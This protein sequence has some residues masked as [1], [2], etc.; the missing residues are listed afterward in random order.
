MEP[1]PVVAVRPKETSLPQVPAPPAQ[2]PQLT[3]EQRQQAYVKLLEGQRYLWSLQNLRSQTSIITNG[4]LARS[5]LQKS[6]EFNPGL[7]EGYT[8][9][10]ELAFFTQNNPSEIERLAGIAVKL[11]RDNFGSHQLL[12]RI[13]SSQSGLFS[14]NLNKTTVDNAVRE[15]REIARLDSRNAEAWAFLSDLYEQTGQ[16]EKQLEALEKWSASANPSDDRFY[17][18]VTRK[19]TLSPEIATVQ[20]GKALLKNGKSAQALT[21]LG[22]AVAENSANPETLAAF[23]EALEKASPD[24]AE[25]AIEVLQQAIL[26]N[27]TSPA[28]V[29]LLVDLQIRSG[30]VDEAAKLLVAARKRFPDDQNLL[31]LE[32]GVLTEM[33]RVDEGVALL[34]SKIVNKSKQI[35]VPE[36]LQDDFMLN[37]LI[38][39]LFVQAGRNTDAIAAAQ[40]ALILANDSQMTTIALLTTATAQ[41]AAGDFKSA[42]LSL[43]EVLKQSP[44]QAMALNNLGYFLI[45]RNE[46]LPEAMELIK[47]AVAREPSNPTYLDSL[48]W[49]NFKL[50]QITEAEKNLTEAARLAPNSAAVQHHLGD[51]YQQQGKTEKARDAWRK[52]L[53]IEKDHTEIEKLKSKLGESKKIKRQ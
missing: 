30:R 42:E 41:N 47:Q 23:K 39:R 45:E 46:R 24:D 52:A 29:Q 11:D 38:S 50:G 8:A 19:E 14:E 40:Q 32:A 12:A 27:P 51:V 17:R 26:S 36:T 5:A 44:N 6:V 21:T 4:R 9:L 18:F 7:A 20:L 25:K 3:R 49:A 22:R 43:R 2:L 13:Y 33:G 28:P 10:A 1:D 37:I 48:G 35:A 34:R 31:R 15:W 16:S 53:S